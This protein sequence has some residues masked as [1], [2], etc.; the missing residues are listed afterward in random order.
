MLRVRRGAA[1]ECCHLDGPAVDLPS[2]GRLA[3]A[4]GQAISSALDRGLSIILRQGSEGSRG[5][6]LYCDEGVFAR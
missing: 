4:L 6:C 3:A 1:G 2:R 5:V